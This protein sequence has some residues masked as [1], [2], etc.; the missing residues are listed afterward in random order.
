[1]NK[2]QENRLSMYLAV[3]KVTNFHSDVWKD[4]KAF[5]TLFAVFEGLLGK[6]REARLVQEGMI[7]GVTKDKT[8]A[9]N[10]AIEKGVEVAKAVYAFASVTGKNKLK[11][12]IAYSP[13]KLKLMRDTMLIDSL[14]VIHNEA[15]KIIDQLQD[16]GITQEGMNEFSELINIYTDAVEN[17]RQA[18]T[19]RV[20][21][22]TELKEYMAQTNTVLKEQ[23]DT[24]IFQFRNINSVFYKQYNNARMIIDLGYRKKAEKSDPETSNANYSA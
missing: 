8:V 1:M 15:I 7:T 18:M 5:R 4:H 22:T 20:R 2:K 11:D 14:S 6:V 9:Q 16:Y 12:R 10:K 13:S 19:N 23:L 3:Q 24:L 21:S 17:P